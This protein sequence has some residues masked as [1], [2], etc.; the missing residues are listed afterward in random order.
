METQKGIGFRPRS[1]LNKVGRG[2][3]RIA[4]APP[5]GWHLLF[6]CTANI[7]NTIFVVVVSTF[8]T[9]GNYAMQQ[10]AKGGFLFLSCGYE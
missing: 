6:A 2:S 5:A 4:V 9:P 8:S 1:T 7:A 10:M 3:G